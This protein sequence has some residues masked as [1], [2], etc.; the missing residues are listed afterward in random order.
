MEKE[1]KKIIKPIILTIISVLLFVQYI[2]TIISA[3]FYFNLE[4]NNKE[5]DVNKLPFG[6]LK[7]DLLKN[8]TNSYTTLSWVISIFII[9]L[10]IIFINL[11]IKSWIKTTTDVDKI[12]K[13]LLT[14]NII[15]YVLSIILLVQSIR[16][17]FIAADKLNVIGGHLLFTLIYPIYW[18][19]THKLITFAILMYLIVKA[20]FNGGQLSDEELHRKYVE[21]K[22]KG[23]Q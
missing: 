5:V 12:K 19:A 3:K 6:I 9:I 18:I 8:E 23:W 21:R 20:F 7:L 4:Y 1:N 11:T 10:F 16:C 13:L 14:K 2:M 17:G 22:L 15:C